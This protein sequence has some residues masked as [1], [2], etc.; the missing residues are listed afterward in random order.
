MMQ[1][2]RRENLKRLVGSGKIS[3]TAR[4][5]GKPS[6]QVADII[7]GRK[8]FGEKV[9]R[10]MEAYA[11]LPEGYF[12]T[13][14]DGENVTM[15][16]IPAQRKIP[17]LSYVQ[18]GEF[19]CA[20]QNVS[21][22]DAINNG[23]FIYASVEVPQNAFGMRIEGESMLPLFK[24]GDIVIVD[25]NIEP[26]PGDFVVARKIDPVTEDPEITFKRYKVLRQTGEG[27]I[28]ELVPLNEFYSTI[29]SDEIPCTIVGVMIE[30]RSFRR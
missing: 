17:I 20:G 4:R 15:A 6:S 9:A 23:D 26:R 25:Q 16:D 29:R 8:S 27:L 30:H 2:L 10:Q 1:D 11:G 24:P 14:H 7:S 3:T 28:F 5:L 22:S 13:R 12:D 18:A 21:T 19:T